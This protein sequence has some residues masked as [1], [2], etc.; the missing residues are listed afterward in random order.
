MNNKSYNL[1]NNI[2]FIKQYISFNKSKKQYFL[3]KK[4]KTFY[5]IIKYKSYY[6]FL[7]YFAL[8]ILII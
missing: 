2:Y 4:L 7:P 1:K 8:L 6:I 5:Q 3:L